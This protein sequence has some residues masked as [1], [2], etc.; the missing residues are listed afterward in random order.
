MNNNNKHSFYVLNYVLGE[1]NECCDGEKEGLFIVYEELTME[2]LTWRRFS[3]D[4]A[5]EEREREVPWQAPRIR[6]QQLVN[7]KKMMFKFGHC[8]TKWFPIKFWDDA[9]C[10]QGNMRT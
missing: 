8:R 5:C 2:G 3:I 10:S 4:M 9:L 1:I 6:L 7:A